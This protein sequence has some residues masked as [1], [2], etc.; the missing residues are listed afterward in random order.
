MPLAKIF[1]KPHFFFAE[2]AI[3][4]ANMRRCYIEFSNIQNIANNGIISEY[5]ASIVEQR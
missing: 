2:N 1:T 4:G 3:N 5:D